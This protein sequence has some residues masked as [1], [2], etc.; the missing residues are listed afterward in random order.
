[1]PYNKSMGLNLKAK[2]TLLILIIAL[3]LSGTSITISNVIISGI[4]KETYRDK[5]ENLAKT[6]SLMVDANAAARL[7]HEVMD[8]YNSIP[9]KV[10][11]E[12]WGTDA[13]NDYVSH[14]NGINKGRVYK[15]LYNTLHFALIANKVDSVYL[16]CVDPVLKNT[17]YIL[18]ASEDPCPI[19]CIDPLDWNEI[20][21]RLID[22]PEIGFPPFI[23]NTKEY[24]WLVTAGVP[25]YDNTGNVSCYAMVD[26]SMAEVKRSQRNFTLALAGV[27]TLITL[28]ICVIAILIV[29][30]NLTKPIS[31]IS[32]AAVKYCHEASDAERN[33]FSLLDIHTG[34]EI[35][36][37]AES[38]KQMECDLNEH[39]R[40]ILDTT[41]ELTL[42]R[43]KADEMT[44][45]AHKDGLTGLRNKV[46][47]DKEVIRLKD[48]LEKGK[49]D[50]GIAMIDL[51]DLK[52][53]NDS[54]GHDKG[55]I[56]IKKLCS[57]VCDIYDHSPVFRIGGDEFVVILERT[58]LEK[59]AELEEI[60]NQH[61]ADLQ[62][63]L[64]LSSWER[65]SAAIGVA[66]FNPILDMSVEDVFKRADNLM[67]ENKRKMKCNHSR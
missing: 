31:M 42:T 32:D 57:I 15:S 40:T 8:I 30:A 41:H 17:I 52:K 44:A 12:E 7:K 48:G 22:N 18:D 20:N 54:F 9:N 56:A 14:Y 58:D 29:N 43:K 38:M 26:I 19:G 47:Y 61:I 60:F 51:N 13:F 62:K 21:L 50:F 37:L 65:V 66:R 34:D 1:M 24:G 59:S 28:I 16:Y 64:E 63:N 45:L 25:L 53:I 23:T 11:S 5:A 55:N 33:G 35:E 67:Y 10:R 36:E 46:A 39:I 4:V 2:T 3:I 6:V 49:N 27:L